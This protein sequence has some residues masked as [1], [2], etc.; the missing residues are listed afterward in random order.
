MYRWVGRAARVVARKLRDAAAITA[1]TAEGRCFGAFGP[2][3][4]LAFPQGALTGIERVHVGAGCIVN[5]H[6]VLCAGLPGASLPGDEPIITIGD[7]CVLGRNAEIL[8]MHSVQLGDDVWFAS[9]VTVVD[10]HHRHDQL[11]IP[12]AVQWPLHVEAVTIG[13]GTVISTGAVVLAG[14]HVGEN[15]LVASGAQVRAGVYPPNS[16]LA[17]VPARVIRTHAPQHDAV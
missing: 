16:V 14:A 1:D 6:T 7:R 4:A 10:H 15:S 17:G 3:S 8:A 9:R 5:E 2:E 13:S 11:D 12:V